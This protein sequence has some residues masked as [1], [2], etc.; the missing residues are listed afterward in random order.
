M[1]QVKINKEQ[2]IREDPFAASGQLGGMRRL[3]KKITSTLERTFNPTATVGRSLSP[4]LRAEE[5]PTLEEQARTEYANQGLDAK[6]TADRMQADVNEA[7]NKVTRQYFHYLTGGLI[8]APENY[9]NT[10]AQQIMD[11]TVKP[12]TGLAAVGTQVVAGSYLLG[13]VSKVPLISTRAANLSATVRGMITGGILDFG[14][15]AAWPEGLPKEER[16]GIS[17]DIARVLAPQ[18]VLDNPTGFAGRALSGVGG[19]VE[20]AILGGVLYGISAGV[21]LAD[22]KYAFTLNSKTMDRMR[23]SLEAAGVDV[24]E[25]S[26]RDVWSTYNTRMSEHIQGIDEAVFNGERMSAQTWVAQAFLADPNVAELTEAEGRLLWGVFS[27]NKG[28]IS[29]IKGVDDPTAAIAKLQR[30]GINVD[31]TVI[32]RKIPGT[33]AT[34]PVTAATEAT[35]AAAV[36]AKTARTRKPRI[37]GVKEVNKARKLVGDEE[38]NFRLNAS[39]KTVTGQV[40]PDVMAAHELAVAQQITG[41]KAATLKAVTQRAVE[42]ERRLADATRVAQTDVLTGLPNAAAWDHMKARVE[43]DPKTWVMAIDLSGFKG[44]NDKISHAFGDEILKKVAPSAHEAAGNLEGFQ[45]IRKGGDEFVA[46]IN[47]A[48]RE[49]ADA[50]AKAIKTKFGQIPIGETGLHVEMRYGLGQTFS[51]ADAAERA[52][53]KAPQAGRYIRPVGPTSLKTQAAQRLYRLALREDAQGTRYAGQLFDQLKTGRLDL[54]G[55]E[56][57]GMRTAFVLRMSGKVN[58]AEELQSVFR[59]VDE[60][61]KKFPK[62]EEFQNALMGYIEGAVKGEKVP[63][64]PT[65]G[66]AI[67]PRGTP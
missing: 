56:S 41:N 65:G 22:A 10:F 40:T 6:Q 57:I 18:S 59:K 64:P 46:T 8:D 42:A 54:R 28:G 1:L 12:M 37:P 9:S 15:N 58:S 60:L 13:W 45:I 32:P 5:G 2:G 50:V 61:G 11:N 26:R 63:L 48:T 38:F 20:G 16:L 3:G 66:P 19:M 24:T 53:G 39:L 14:I 49:E 23:K 47:A 7:G 21:K 44:A 67:P 27:S 17:D 35:E 34:A 36:G 30:V 55:E 51:E 52:L 25:M 29:V 31:V 4:Q 33:V 62:S 43:G